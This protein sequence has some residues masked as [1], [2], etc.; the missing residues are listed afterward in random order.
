MLCLT[1]SN[2][3]QQL[4][5]ASGNA[6]VP[7]DTL[8]FAYIQRAQPS[9]CSVDQYVL[10]TRSEMT[11]MAPFQMDLQSA[12]AIGGAT[13]LTMAVAWVIRMVIKALQHS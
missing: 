8:A 11:V 2:V 3:N 12:V 1:L 4:G 13:L 10:L 7:A 9:D 6:F 5:K